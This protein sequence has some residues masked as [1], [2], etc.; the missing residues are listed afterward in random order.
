MEKPEKYTVDGKVLP[1][2]TYE[3]LAEI[4][5]LDIQ[6]AVKKSSENLKDYMLA[7]KQQVKAQNDL[8]KDNK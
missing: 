8:K 3:K 1:Q 7:I 6:S 2:K 5:E 4:T